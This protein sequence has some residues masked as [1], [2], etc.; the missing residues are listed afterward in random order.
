M[1]FVSFAVL[2][3]RIKSIKA[4]LKDPN[5]PKRK[6]FLVIFGIIYL[7]MPI[8]LIQ[9]CIRDRV[10][11][12]ELPE[13]DDDLA[14]EC[15]EFDTLEEWKEDIRRRVED[16]KKQQNENRAQNEIL[17]T[18]Y[19]ETV[20]DIPE[21]VSY[22]HLD[23]Y[24]RQVSYQ[25]RPGRCGRLLYSAGRSRKMCGDRTAYG[26]SGLCGLQSG[27]YDLYGNSGGRESQC[28]FHRYRRTVRGDR[29]GRT[30]QSGRSHF[31]PRRDLRRDRS[32]R[33]LRRSG[34]GIGGCENGRNQQG[35]CA[36]G[37][38]GGSRFSGTLRC[39]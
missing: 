22:T 21:A 1:Q 11:E 4:L 17:K 12:E 25:M 3:K 23:V 9:M 2:G 24:K 6:K 5:V 33:A 30:G 34:S 31:H 27:I 8:D 15:S 18:L 19:E 16:N 29:Y 28:C 37:V 14:K 38:S 36:D 20:I 10:M 13:I 32:G 35:I 26:K 39:V 7:L